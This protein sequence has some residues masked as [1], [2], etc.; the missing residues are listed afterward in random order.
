ML[1]N[2][3]EKGLN[4][5]L[6]DTFYYILKCEEASLQQ[7]LNVPVTL[8][9]AH[10]IDTIGRQERKESSVSRIARLLNIAMPTA[11][12][13]VKKME[14]KGFVKKQPC[15][16][17]ARRTIISLTDVGRKI[18]KIHHLFHEKMV[19]NIS[20]QLQD[21]EKEILL[22]TTR[23]LSEFFRS[24]AEQLNEVQPNQA[25]PAF[26]FHPKSTRLRRSAYTKRMAY[27]G[28]PIDH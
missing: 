13:A 18:E 19:R 6:I 4:L 20:G 28:N 11:T 16:S 27:G 2:E 22:S 10:M 14:K 1:V 3:F 12:V 5:A 8:T 17:D 15:E 25:K 23:K 26:W 21:G 24:T 9:E 7:L